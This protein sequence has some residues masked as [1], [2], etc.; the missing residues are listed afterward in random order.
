MLGLAATLISGQVYGDS[1][2]TTR[3]STFTGGLGI[4]VGAF[5]AAGLFLTAIPE[6]VVLALDALAG[7]FFIAGGIVSDPFSI[8]QTY[9]IT[10]LIHIPP[11]RS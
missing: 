6:L 11:C 1:P 5:G 10:A 2:V 8:V 7:I 4:I 9:L 3:Y